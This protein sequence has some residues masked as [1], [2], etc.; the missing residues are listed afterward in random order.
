MPNINS[1][2]PVQD[3][4]LESVTW[5]VAQGE[6]QA[7]QVFIVVTIP[8]PEVKVINAFRKYPGWHTL[9]AA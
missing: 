6:L 1:Y 3:V 5:Q 2:V 9:H 8:S 7:L 4:Q